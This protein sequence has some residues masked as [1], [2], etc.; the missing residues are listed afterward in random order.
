LAEVVM[1]HLGVEVTADSVCAGNLGLRV[2]S[3]GVT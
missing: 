1:G 3:D 2:G